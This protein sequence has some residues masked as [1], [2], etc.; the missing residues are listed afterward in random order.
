MSLLKNNETEKKR[1]YAERVIEIEHGT[2]TPLVFS[3]NGVVADETD[4]FLKELST[5]LSDKIKQPY[6]ECIDYIRTRVRISLL[7]SSLISL[8]GARSKSSK[9]T[10]DDHNLHFL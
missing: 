1:K 10:F 8:R 2:F 3:T 5:K 9:C 7:R 6:A 4:K